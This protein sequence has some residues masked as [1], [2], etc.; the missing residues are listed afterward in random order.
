[1]VKYLIFLLASACISFIC[2][3]V[4][5]RLAIKTN[6][7]DLP[8]QRKIHLKSTPLLGGV[9]IFISFNLTILAGV[10]LNNT[11]IKEFILPRWWL[12]LVCQIIILAMGITDDILKLKPAIKFS[13]Q[14]FVGVLMTLFGFGIH[15]ISN[16]FGENIIHLGILSIPI[17]IVWLVGITNALNLVDGLDG[18]AS[19]TSIIVGITIFAIAFLNENIGIALVSLALVG[20]VA[21]FLKY[22]FHPAKIFLGDSGSLLLGFLLAVL[23]IESSSKGATLLAVLAPILALGFPIM[24]TLLSMI[25]RFLKSIHLVNYPNEEKTVR[26]AFIKSFSI[27]KADKS[28]VHHQLLKLGFS[29]RKAV[30]SLYTLCLILC[31]LAFLSVAL[32]DLNNFILLGAIFL[33]FAIGIRTLNYQEFK[34][35]ENG[36]L[37]PIFSFPVISKSIFQAVFDLSVISVSFY[38]SFML[39]SGGLIGDARNLFFQ[40]L[41]IIL[42]L[43]LAIFYF[44]GLY[45]GT[46][47]YSSF[48]DIFIVVKAVFYSSFGSLIVLALAFGIGALGGIIFFLLDFYL[49]I[50]FVLGFRLSNKILNNYY[51]K[52]KQNE[53]KI[54]IYGAGYKGSTV[55]KELRHN[56]SYSLLPIGFIDD[57]L[58]KKGKVLHSCPIL[59]SI[60]DIEDVISNNEISEI[61]ISTRKIAKEKIV[62]LTKYCKT[63]NISIRQFEFRFYEFT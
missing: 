19:G 41:P 3:P 53:K 56:G 44:T 45:K 8:S 21:G 4:I 10:L 25:R 36:L 7:V 30:L 28:H 1:M 27:F 48:E 52:S 23:S 37:L 39:V 6:I 22:N 9:P 15:S 32:K 47:K 18:L 54:L 49:L 12:L 34:I 20:A 17:T 58:S 46:W 43:K 40:C 50:S 57:D 62:E 55:L 29:H 26:L 33:A 51:K 13:F 14:I 24:D 61:I 42:I 16:P 2:T 31:A 59:G 11:Y 60:D 5:R 63:Q 35:L 38:L